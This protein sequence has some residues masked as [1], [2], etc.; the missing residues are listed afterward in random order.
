M[1]YLGWPI[2]QTASAK[3]MA[4]QP[5]TQISQTLSAQS[6]VDAASG[7]PVVVNAA[8]IGPLDLAT[9]TR[10]FALPWSAYVRLLS[11]KSPTARGFYEAEALRCG[12]TVRQLD[13][14]VNKR[15]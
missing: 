2:P 12:W 10:R 11:V 1:F 4:G 8:A 14:R 5:A 7:E 6:G 15:Y 9:L 13:R 3:S